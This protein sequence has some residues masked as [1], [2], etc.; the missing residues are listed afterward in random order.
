MTV[1]QGGLTQKTS[2]SLLI[3][4]LN[5]Y[6]RTKLIND[7]VKWAEANHIPYLIKSKDTLSDLN[8][9]IISLIYLPLLHDVKCLENAPDSIPIVMDFD[10]ALGGLID[11]S[12]ILE[13]HPYAFRRA[14]GGPIKYSP[15]FQV[16]YIHLPLEL[17]PSNKRDVIIVDTHQWMQLPWQLSMLA[18]LSHIA[19]EYDRLCKMAGCQ[20]KIYLTSFVKLDR[21]KEATEILDRFRN[22]H[23]GS[24][25]I[26][27]TLDIIKDNL[28]PSMEDISDYHNLFTRARLF[29]SDHGELADQDIM[30]AGCAG[31][32]IYLISRNPLR[33]SLGITSS[34][35]EAFKVVDK[36]FGDFFEGAKSILCGPSPNY[37]NLFKKNDFPSW[38]ND[39]IKKVYM[40]I[41]DL[42]WHWAKTGEAD[43]SVNEAIKESGKWK[44]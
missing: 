4:N 15:N 23:P 16:P 10:G 30:H 33:P 2:M 35:L 19:L 6:R 12:Q 13:R 11:N 9:G 36:E 5:Q 40:K 39:Y 22:D 41:W 29:V 31:V 18:F 38:D 25:K 14:F 26:S 37:H 20:L 27:G 1:H 32:P 17:E 28:I 42:L 3:V 21:F 7:V 24:I 44:F 8:W 34:I 43:F